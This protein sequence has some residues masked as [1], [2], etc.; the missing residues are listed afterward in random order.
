MRM[1]KSASCSG[2][3]VAPTTTLFVTAVR[4]LSHAH[5][6]GSVHDLP[7]SSLYSLTPLRRGFGPSEGV[8]KECKKYNA[9][10]AEKL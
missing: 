10:K 8:I 6:A 1:K 2:L 3:V 4:R 9:K 5:L 7:P